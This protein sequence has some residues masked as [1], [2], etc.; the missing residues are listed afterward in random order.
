MPSRTPAYAIAARETILDTAEAR[1]SLMTLAPGQAVPPHHHTVV[2][3][4]TFCL[5]GLAEVVCRAPDERFPLAPGDRATVPPGRVHELRNSGTE[6]CRV[7]LVQGPGGYDF[8][9]D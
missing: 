6:P 8:V 2:T 5:A 1:V 9:P 3:D 7:L 4:D